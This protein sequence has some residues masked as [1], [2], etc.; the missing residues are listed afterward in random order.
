[1]RAIPLAVPLVWTTAGVFFLQ[2]AHFGFD[3]GCDC[4]RFRRL[5]R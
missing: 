5:I 3:T 2:G 1:M 4:R